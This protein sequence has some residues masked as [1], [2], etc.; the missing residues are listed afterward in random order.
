MKLQIIQTKAPKKIT[1]IRP[2]LSASFPL[3]G[4]EINAVTVN[5]AMI[6]PF[7]SGAPSS[8]RYAGRTGMIM[9]KLAKNRSE[10]RQSN[11]KCFE[12]SSAFK[13]VSFNNYQSIKTKVMLV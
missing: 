11:Q 12:Y 4:R 9:L 6:N 13:C 3:K 7:N 10:L 2:I 8:D 1:G 5:K